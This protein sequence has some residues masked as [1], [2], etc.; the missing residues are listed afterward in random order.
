M[1]SENDI[2]NQCLYTAQ[3]HQAYDNHDFL[4]NYKYKVRCRIFKY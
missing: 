2:K 4:R 3:R 1:S